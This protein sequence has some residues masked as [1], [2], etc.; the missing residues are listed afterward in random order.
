[1]YLTVY[2]FSKICC[3]ARGAKTFTTVASYFVRPHE[4]FCTCRF[5]SAEDVQSI[6][7]KEWLCLFVRNANNPSYAAMCLSSS[8]IVSLVK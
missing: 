3:V 4:N 6:D 8:V 2:S 1:M 7:R 5:F